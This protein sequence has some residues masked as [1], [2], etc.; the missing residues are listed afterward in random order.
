[1]TAE[2]NSFALPPEEDY[3]PADVLLGERALEVASQALARMDPEIELQSIV[4]T[5]IGYTPSERIRVNYTITVAYPDGDVRDEDL[6]AVAGGDGPPAGAH[7]VETGAGPIGYWRYPWDPHL[8]GLEVAWDMAS[9]VGMLE[10]ADIQVES[11][12]V[13]SHMSYAPAY[14]A[15]LRVEFEERTGRSR[16]K[17]VSERTLYLKVVRPAEIGHIQA[18]HV[19]L[20]G[21]VPSPRCLAW[22]ASLGLLL[23]DEVQGRSVWELLVSGEPPPD[24]EVFLEVMDRL[25]GIELPG[26]PQATSGDIA[27]ACGKTLVAVMPEEA[28]RVTRLVDYYAAEVAQPIVTIHGDF[29]EDQ[30]L[31]SPDGS[32]AGIIDLD[33]V[34][35]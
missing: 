33:E 20:Q 8:P 2:G 1:M 10:A 35:P 9:I 15:V 28:E 13:V 5:Y 21:H 4:P 18:A 3:P 19:A 12:P 11:A 14:H 17:G 32:I 27:V 6:I 29:H 26:N 34:G 25:S 7:V 24:P 23:L 30:V 16:R 31:L 22:S